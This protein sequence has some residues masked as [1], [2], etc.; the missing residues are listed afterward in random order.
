MHEIKKLVEQ[1]YLLPLELGKG[2]LDVLQADD[3]R[4]VGAVDPG[5]LAGSVVGH[6][7]LRRVR[8]H[9]DLLTVF[10]F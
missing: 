2:L 10:V 4:E 8:F 5:L 9:R 6:I 3:G 1:L 7:L